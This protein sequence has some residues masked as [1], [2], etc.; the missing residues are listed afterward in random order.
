MIQID[1]NTLRLAR[2]LLSLDADRTLIIGAI[3]TALKSASTPPQ[4]AGKPPVPE[5]M[6]KVQE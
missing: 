3:D 4:A 5:R 2:T 1:E 6:E